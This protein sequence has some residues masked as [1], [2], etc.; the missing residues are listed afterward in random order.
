MNNNDT[1]TLPREVVEQALEALTNCT[2][3]YGHRCNRCDSEVDPDGNVASA[4]RAAL[5]QAPVAWRPVVGFEGLYEVSS[6]GDIRNLKTNVV[7]AKNKM[8]A[9]YIKADLW[10]LGTRT[11][12]SA[13]RVVAEAFLGSADGLEVNHING[14]KADNRVSN[15]EIVTKNENE[16]HSRYVLGNL[17]KPVIARNLTSGS[18]FELESVNAARDAGFLPSSVYKCCYGICKQH[19]GHAFRFKNPDHAN[20]EKVT[21][22]T[23]PQPPRQPPRQPLTDEEVKA[24]CYTGPVYAPD[25]KVTR[26]PEQYKREIAD[27]RMHGIRQAER[28]HGI[29][30][31]K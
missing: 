13:H 9:G 16:S 11:Q 28:A 8:G 2:I 25:G 22:N 3:E 23:H 20:N 24:I 18:E 6:K 15:L 1:V 27:A 31:D 12:T 5:E 17:V 7:L 19:K 21:S 4:L 29:G 14:D 26:T 10:K 30:G